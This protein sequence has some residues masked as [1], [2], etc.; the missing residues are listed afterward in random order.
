[1]TVQRRDGHLSVFYLGSS[2]P[3]PLPKQDCSHWCLPG[4][5]DTWNELLYALILNRELRRGRLVIRRGD[6]R[7]RG[8]AVRADS[9]ESAF[10]R[11]RVRCR[12]AHAL[13]RGRRRDFGHS[14][15]NGG[16][17][18]PQGPWQRSSRLLLVALGAVVV[19]A[20]LFLAFSPSINEGGRHAT[21]EASLAVQA[22]DLKPKTDRSCAT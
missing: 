6:E 9:V 12:S 14:G 18:P 17:G 4:V 8:A 13:W 22:R 10:E 5:P 2:G 7:C 19:V 20:L 16:P 3:A 15:G 21:G 1:M 11:P